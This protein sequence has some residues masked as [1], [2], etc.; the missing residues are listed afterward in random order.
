MIP[1]K[2][3]SRGIQSKSIQGLGLIDL[4]DWKM[5]KFDKKNWFFIRFRTL[6]NILDQQINRLIFRGGGLHIVNENKPSSYIWQETKTYLLLSTTKC[7]WI[8]WRNK[9]FL[10]D[11][12]GFPLEPELN[13][14]SLQIQCSL[15]YTLVFD[16]IYDNFLFFKWMF[17]QTS[18][19]L[20]FS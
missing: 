5:N 11:F 12:H 6:R 14:M 18:I 1:N 2:Q 16:N 3:F 7:N 9:P 17:K 13:I 20:M 19:H 10:I 8:S 15:F 4:I